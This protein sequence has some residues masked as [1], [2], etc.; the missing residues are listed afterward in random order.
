MTTKANNK[1]KKGRI[2]FYTFSTRLKYEERNELLT[3]CRIMETTPSELIR[4]LLLKKFE[5]EKGN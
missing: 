5:F 1:H 2:R 4:E 3:W